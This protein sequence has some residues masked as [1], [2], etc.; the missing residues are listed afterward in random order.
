VELARRGA[1]RL[2]LARGLAALGNV[3]WARGR[4][5]DARGLARAARRVVDACRDPGRVADRV[6][7]LERRAHVAAAPEAPRDALSESELAVLRV[8]PSQL[9]NRE[10]GEQLYI[11]VN[12]VKTHLRNIYGKL[13]VT[14]R[15]Q[16]VGRARELGLL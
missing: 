15:D 5:E 16:A 3:H 11:S 12:T 13:R 6:R 9:S 1:G 4:R 7:E 14:S 8:L 10:I 2:E